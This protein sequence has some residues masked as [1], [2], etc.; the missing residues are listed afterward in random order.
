MPLNKLI[1]RASRILAVAA[2]AFGLTAGN[3]TA[4]DYVIPGTIGTSP[5]VMTNF[6]GAGSFLDN[7]QFTLGAIGAIGSGGTPI[8][9]SIGPLSILNMAFTGGSIYAGSIASPGAM[10]GSFTNS[11]G[12]L[13][14]SG[15]LA[16]YGTY[17]ASLAGTAS[18]AYGGSYAF[19]IAAVPEPGQ[20]L[21]FLAGIA[22][23]G[24]MVHRR[25]A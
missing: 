23:L 9:L 22:M 5:T 4:A 12:V 2:F 10:V 25:A 19:T 7:I 3:A 14:F 17:F 1:Q 16:P 24:A 20:W 13:S 18:G 6:V 21:M 11:G 8:N 15:L